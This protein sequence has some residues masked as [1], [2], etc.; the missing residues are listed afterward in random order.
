[1]IVDILESIRKGWWV[2]FSFSHFVGK[3][4]VVCLFIFSSTTVI[5]L[6]FDALGYKDLITFIK[7]FGAVYG[8]ILPW[9]ATSIL[10]ASTVAIGHMRN[11]EINEEKLSVEVNERLKK[12]YEAKREKDNKNKVNLV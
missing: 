4:L 5:N 10:L 12:E 2:I 3:L 1:M 9:A 6:F 7:P 8:E 11:L